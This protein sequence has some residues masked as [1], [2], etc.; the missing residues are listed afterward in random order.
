MLAFFSCGHVPVV[1]SF[2]VLGMM[3]VRSVKMNAFLAGASISDSQS[4]Q[5]ALDMLV[6]RPSTPEEATITR[7]RIEVMARIRCM[8]FERKKIHLL[9]I[10]TMAMIQR[11][12]KGPDK[13]LLLQNVAKPVC[14]HFQIDP[15]FP[16]HQLVP[17]NLE[18]ANT[19]FAINPLVLLT[20]SMTSMLNSECLL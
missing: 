6:R 13:Q 8:F 18:I 5:L 12:K 2:V 1:M 19:L 7:T 17:S 14:Q 9:Q 16:L 11:R 3:K 15:P 4:L 20:K 10:V